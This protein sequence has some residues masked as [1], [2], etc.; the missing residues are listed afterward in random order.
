M[1]SIIPDEETN[2]DVTGNNVE[3]SWPANK[4]K[5]IQTFAWRYI[6]TLRKQIQCL[7]KT[8]NIQ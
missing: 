8:I 5:A 7:I 2:R 3:N 1:Q 6:P 4:R